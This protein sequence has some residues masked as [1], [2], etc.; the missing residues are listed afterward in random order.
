MDEPHGGP[1]T[2]R[3]RLLAEDASFDA[4]TDRPLL[5]SAHDA[6]WPLAS[7]CRNGTCRTCIRR[8]RSGAVTYRIAWPGL[9]AEE[10]AEGWFLPCVAYPAGDL[11]VE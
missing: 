5:A 9:L 7:S 10:K 2:F 8:L 4:R 1:G 3:V 11:V 6:G